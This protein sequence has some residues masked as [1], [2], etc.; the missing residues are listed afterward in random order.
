[1]QPEIE[2][3]SQI[4]QQ[5]TVVPQTPSKPAPPTKPKKGMKLVILIILIT[6]VS[7]SIGGFFIWK[8]FSGSK[9]SFPGM[10]KTEEE[11]YIYK[12]LWMST[13]LF[14]DVNY[15]ESN[16][17]KL[18]D[19]GVNTIYIVA[20]PPY[21]K[22]SFEK[23]KETFAPEIVET[24]RELIPIEK[25]LIINNIQIAHNNGLKVALSVIKP[26]VLEEK[27]IEEL[28]LK[29]IE[30]AR[31]AEKYDV[32]LFA[33]LAEP[34]TLIS[35][36]IAKWRQEIF[37][38]VK[39]VYNGEVYWSSPGVGSPPDKAEI[40]QIAEQPPGDFAGYDYI[41]LTTLLWISERLEP[42]EKIRYADRLTLEGY[43]Q[44]VEGAIDYMLAVAER[45]GAKGVI[46]TE[47]GVIGT[48][49]MSESRI[50]SLS[51]EVFAEA[52]EI[53]LEQGNG[54]VVGFFANDDFLGIELTGIP[55]LKENL[56]TQEV[57]K[58]YFTEILPEKKLIVY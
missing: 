35:G 19:M 52:Y 23:L 39:K 34:N 45:D 42:E 26:P 57:I 27:D 13:L 29:I 12:G 4:P 5:P 36:D 49:A 38:K 24:F 53:V 18:K 16:I 14:K 10:Q 20:F 31:L 11:V 43:S 6:L 2:D 3:V 7:L 9:I 47:F 1:V 41:G 46:I 48:I 51:E 30:Y 8:Y 58:R 21:P 22:A 28:N 50:L 32:E 54:K 40:S 56:K 44:H 33:P 17:Q 55:L 25:E 15:L 37:P